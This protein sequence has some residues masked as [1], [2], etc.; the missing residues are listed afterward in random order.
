MELIPANF[1]VGIRNTH[2]HFRYCFIHP[3]NMWVA[4]FV[5]SE[6][7][8][9]LDGPW[10]KCWI[11]ISVVF[12]FLYGI[13]PSIHLFIRLVIVLAIFRA[14]HF[15]CAAACRSNYCFDRPIYDN[16]PISL[17]LLRSFTTFLS[18]PNVDKNVTNQH[19]TEWPSIWNGYIWAMCSAC[20]YSVTRFRHQ[21]NK[22]KWKRNK[23]AKWFF[24]SFFLCVW[25]GRVAFT[26]YSCDVCAVR[27]PTIT[28]N[29]SGS[30]NK[31]FK[32]LVSMPNPSIPCDCCCSS[33]AHATLRWQCSLVA[34][35]HL[36]NHDTKV[37]FVA[38]C[39]LHTA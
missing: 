19:G 20:L 30:N 29:S 27:S 25:C 31:K 23:Y 21:R 1:A 38:F 8:F 22:L 32:R 18:R 3:L 36:A 26:N 17:V 35:C 10:T 5:V 28:L 39:S 2:T 14:I 9:C 15:D 6:L 34:N 7:T 4:R 12:F 11:C 33:V 24:F 16:W 13:R 37:V